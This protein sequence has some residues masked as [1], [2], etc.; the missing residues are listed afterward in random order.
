MTTEDF[1]KMVAI[2]I[3]LGYKKIPKYR[4]AWNSSSLCYDSYVAQ[5]MSRNKFEALMAF[6]HVVDKEQEDQL[7]QDKDKLLKVRP[8]YDYI[9]TQCQKFCQPGEELSID[10]R[11]VRSKAHF[12]FKQYIRNKPTKWGFKLWCLCNASN[13]YTVNFSIYRGKTGEI[14]S[15]N[16]LSYDVVV[17]LMDNYLDQ[18]YNLFVDNFYTSP[19]LASDLFARKTHL[20]GTLDRSRKNTPPEVDDCFDKLSQK[21]TT[22]GEG[23]YV[24][25]GCIV[26]SVWKD[27]KCISVL[28]T[29]YPGYS[30][31]TVKRNSKDS[32]GRHEKRDVPI[33]SPVYH[34]N[35]YMGGVDKS[36]QLIHYYNVL[37]S[38]KKYWKTLF[39]HFIDI[40]VVNSY[41]IHQH[42][43][44]NPVSHYEFRENLVRLMSGVPAPL[45]AEEPAMTESH[46]SVQ[47]HCRSAAMRRNLIV[48]L[49][50]V[51]EHYPITMSKRS[52][53]VYCKLTGSVDHYSSRQCA[54][55]KVALC[56]IDR[57]CFTKW[58]DPNFTRRRKRWN[59]SS[60]EVTQS[61]N[62][63][64]RL[65]I[66]LAKRGRP[67][68][69][70]KTKGRGRRRKQKW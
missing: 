52:H 19:T 23:L 28:S 51:S 32:E 53:C 58:H 64:T 25:D 2:F 34:Y 35:K 60:N 3:H 41:I 22:R 38:S 55:C 61:T 42:K 65:E 26:Y 48:D 20:T 50:M 57:D 36:D 1:Y 39:F 37:R 5:I 56:T 4:L 67:Q 18:G 68:G 12:S 13:G 43:V 9:N 63:A 15:G 45:P 10:E 24:R 33:P 7:R 62:E 6:L 14:I 11:M 21:S 69:S 27:T 70:V 49:C 47:E 66:T 40:A 30:E 8:L 17:R 46:S 59:Q 54:E 29:R 31:N 16:G 44:S